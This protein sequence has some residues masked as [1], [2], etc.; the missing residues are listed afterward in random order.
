MNFPIEITDY[1]TWEIVAFGVEFT[2]TWL[3][4]TYSWHNLRR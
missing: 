2:M 1:P 4:H 3:V